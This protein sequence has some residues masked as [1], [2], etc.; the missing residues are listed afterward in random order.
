VIVA[1]FV[2]AVGTI[3]NGL[4][5]WVAV[6]AGMLAGYRGVSRG[7]V[8]ALTALTAGYF[9]LRFAVLDVGTPDLLERSSGFGFE[10]LEPAQLVQRFG[11]NPLPL[12]AYNVASALSTVLFGEPRNGLLVLGRAAVEDSIRPWMIVDL[13]SSA[14]VT[15]LIGWYAWS[16]SWRRSVRHW[17]DGQRLVAVAAAVIVANAVMSY[18]YAKDE[19]M[20]ASG[21]YFAA[22]VAV[23][24]AG[25]AQSAPRAAW[26]RAAALVLVAVAATGWSWRVAGVQHGLAHAA[27]AH[28]NDWATVDPASAAAPFGSHP[29]LVALIGSMRQRALARTAAYPVLRSPRFAEEW[30]DH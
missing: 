29:D 26:A 7:G 14:A 19:I 12:Y 8:A 21:P 6:V 5:I 4:L 2:L 3:E 20:T 10:R 24:I 25:L 9:V 22:A 28:R 30:F 1:A 11:T 23:S 17:T 18:A 27:F 13:L 16:V 15:L